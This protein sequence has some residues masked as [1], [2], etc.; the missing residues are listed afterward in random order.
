MDLN[1]LLVFN[2]PST[3]GRRDRLQGGGG[4]GE[5]HTPQGT[6][7]ARIF[8]KLDAIEQ[9]FAEHIQLADA[10]DGMVPE[11]V[12]VLE[13][14]G[15]PGEL[16]NRLSRIEGLEFM[17]SVV[18][19][20]KYSDDDFYVLTDGERKPVTRTLYLSMSNQAGLQR[21]RR[22]WTAFNDNRIIDRGFTP[23]TN[24]FS[25]LIDIRAWSTKD[26]L[27]STRLLEDWTERVEHIEEYGDEYVPFEIELWYRSSPVR[28][29]QSEILLREVIERSGGRIDK[30]CLHSGIH[31]H[32]LLGFLPVSRVSE[33]LE[34][35]AEVL[36]IMRC[37]DVMFFR[38]L[39]QC[40][41]PG[42]TLEDIGDPG[43]P[44]LPELREDE[45]LS[46]PSVALLDGLP[47][48]NHLALRGRI[49]VDD[50]DE[51]AEM[52]ATA[53]EQVHGT[54]MASLI[55]HGDMNGQ[56]ESPL[57]RRLY[58]RPI[59]APEGIQAEG[60]RRDEHIPVAYLPVDLIH[61][62]VLRMKRGS[63]E[64]GPTAP[65]VVIINLSVGDRY[66]LFDT[67]MSPFARML[68][69]LSFT[70]KVLFVVSAG[71]HDPSLHLEGVQE[72][73]FNAMTPVQLEEA[74]LRAVI[75]QRHLRRMMSPAEA[76]NAITVSAVH[77]DQYAGPLPVRRIDVLSQCGLFSPTNPITLGRRNMIKPEIMMPGGRLTYVN[78]TYRARDDVVLTSPASNAQGP[79][80]K[81]ALPSPLPGN[82]NGYGYTAGT[83]NAAAL[84]TRRLA[85]LYESLQDMKAF[86]ESQAL[87]HAPDAVILKALMVHGAEYQAVAR[88]VIEQHFKTRETSR[89]FKSH[90]NQMFGY[91]RVNETRI[92]GCLNNQATLI[93]TGTIGHE[94]SQDYTLPLPVSLSAVTVSRRL[95][96][97]LA[98]LSPIRYD[99]QDYRVAQLWAS[100]GQD[101]LNVNE[102]DYYHHYL[103]NGTV[104]HEVRTGEDASIF[105][106]ND[107]INI[108]VNCRLLAGITEM[109]I[110]YALVV[111]LDT[112]DVNVP[113]YQEVRTLLEVDAARQ[114]VR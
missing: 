7:A 65:G 55:I 23:V 97:T 20:E 84:A 105:T 104:F 100:P 86:D 91:G 45:E 102:A 29:Q 114:Q 42:V 52:Y 113:V 10:P 4:G 1:P 70:Y 60:R 111:T 49:E 74:A 21:L 67:Q 12:L 110:P 28:R 47:L 43:L 18:E 3:Y 25:Q 51:F 68:D 81:T 39:G 56:P 44:Q 79:G 96:I 53:T 98:W 19:K 66:R 17:T 2:A 83:S 63:A 99:H 90:L 109:N 13:V 24:A 87:S 112:P 40:Y 76:I 88:E 8:P 36:E 30:T 58:V 16:S 103:K 62:A 48:E 57:E 38:P 27:E 35:G 71:N 78:N 73:Q 41:T 93:H 6:Q 26:R 34:Q 15:D 108:R 33:V 106:E 50:P 31:Y 75:R 5:L 72:Q 61:R 94:Q 11:K 80:I 101:L 9:T 92:H 64:I 37:D 54:S 89:T 82:V 22:M 85:F 14:A 69:W 32:A 59:M 107:R 46:S 95:I 77:E